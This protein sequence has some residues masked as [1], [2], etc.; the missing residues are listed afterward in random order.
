MLRSVAPCLACALFFATSAAGYEL[1]LVRDRDANYTAV[2][3]GLPPGEPDVVYVGVGSFLPG[4]LVSY[5]LYLDTQGQSDILGFSVGLTFESS[6]LIYRPDLSDADDYPLY[7]PAAG[8]SMPA[9]WLEP[10]S[11]PPQ[12]WAAPPVGRGQVNVEFREWA[13]KNTFATGTNVYLAT[14]VFEISGEHYGELGWDEYAS[15]MDLGLDYGGNGFFVGSP[16]VDLAPDLVSTQIVWA[17]E[18]STAVLL[19]VGVA[20]LV[21]L[22]RR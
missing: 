4:S 12:L 2:P 13:Y 19:G 15:V 17:P 6:L 18:P 8:K 16:A 9:S 7:S 10:S 5:S 20:W 1:T 21:A 3:Y 14:L 22:R 11:D